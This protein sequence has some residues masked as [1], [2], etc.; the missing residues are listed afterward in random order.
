VTRFPSLALRWLIL[1]SLV[2]VAACGST[3]KRSSGGRER[4]CLARAMYFES[5]RSS[6]DG[7][8]AVGTVVMNRVQSGQYP[9]SVCGVV[10]QKNQFAPGVLSKPMNEGHS[11]ALAEQVADAVLRGKRHRGV[12]DRAMFF[13][14]AGHRFPYRNMHYVYVAGGNAFYEKRKGTTN[15]PRRQDHL[16]AQAARREPGAHR[17][18]VAMVGGK[19]S[20]ARAAKPVMMAEARTVAPAARSDAF[21]PAPAPMQAPVQAYAPVAT[22]SIEDLILANG[23]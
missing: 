6:A 19:P 7:M 11:R 2:F 18:A 4:Q 15:D 3:P 12:G 21:I 10:G 17:T 9:G 5:N 8:L 13:H 20:R 22:P 16:L 23:Y 14:T 1:V